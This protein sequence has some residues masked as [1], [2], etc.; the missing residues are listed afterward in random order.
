MNIFLEI[1]ID[2]VEQL[3][4]AEKREKKFFRIFSPFFSA[5][6]YNLWIKMYKFRKCSV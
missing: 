6:N 5:I 4:A 2:E 1:D 3:N